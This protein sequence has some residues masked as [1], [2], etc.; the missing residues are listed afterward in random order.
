MSRAVFIFKAL[1]S[2]DALDESHVVS[3]YPKELPEQGTIILRDMDPE[4]YLPA[5]CWLE[6]RFWSGKREE[7]PDKETASG[8][9]DRSIVMATVNLAHYLGDEAAYTYAKERLVFMVAM[10]EVD[11]LAEWRPILGISQD[12][13]FESDLDVA[14]TELEHRFVHLGE[15][16]S[17]AWDAGGKWGLR[18]R[19]EYEAC[20]ERAK[21]AG[22]IPK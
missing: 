21:E 11:Q 5:L 20:V 12:G 19:G 22:V 10:T 2:D 4:V 8:F 3:N 17:Q 18:T 15:S 6:E 13:D 9:D 7:N 14:K 16:P 1:E